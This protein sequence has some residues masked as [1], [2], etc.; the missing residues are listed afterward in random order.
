[1]ITKGD[2]FKLLG[3][4]P[5]DQLPKTLIIDDGSY[6]G[7]FSQPFDFIPDN[8]WPSFQYVALTPIRVYSRYQWSVLQEAKRLLDKGL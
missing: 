1:M 4:I 6:K 7:L 3:M 2:I 5:V 8:E